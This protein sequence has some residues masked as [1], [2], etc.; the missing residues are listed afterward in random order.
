MDRRWIGDG[1]GIPPDEREQVFETG[2][3]TGEG[4]TGFGLSICRRIAEAHGGE[5]R[6]TESEGGGARFEFA[7]VESVD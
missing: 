2:H 7:G 3:T 6:A 1:P 5:L 4:W